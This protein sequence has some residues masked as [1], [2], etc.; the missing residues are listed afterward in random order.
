M[1][2]LQKEGEIGV[3]SLYMMKED[4]LDRNPTTPPWPSGQG[5]M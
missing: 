4:A 1:R 2:A 5:D 3:V